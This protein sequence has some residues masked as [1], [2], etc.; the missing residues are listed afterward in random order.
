MAEVTFGASTPPCNAAAEVTFGST[1]KPILPSTTSDVQEGA[2]GVTF[3]NKTA[4][5]E[6]AQLGEHPPVATGNNA[7]NPVAFENDGVD[8]ITG[9][10]GDPLFTN[11]TAPGSVVQ[12][13]PDTLNFWTTGPEVEGMYY[14]PRSPVGANEY[15]TYDEPTKYNP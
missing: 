1:Q 7:A 14:M 5:V 11:A 8:L 3:A 6:V 15:T 10:K 4:V 2:A 9:A 13:G 12:L